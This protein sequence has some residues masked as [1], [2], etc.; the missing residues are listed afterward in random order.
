MLLLATCELMSTL[1]SLSFVVWGY[2]LC[3]FGSHFFIATELCRHLLSV[4]RFP[5]PLKCQ[6]LLFVLENYARWLINLPTLWSWVILFP[7]RGN[8]GRRPSQFHHSV[9]LPN[10]LVI[11]KLPS[12]LKNMLCWHGFIVFCSESRIN[13]KTKSLLDFQR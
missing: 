5:S 7:M 3:L 6:S 13:D 2:L 4:L 11:K 8:L 9:R 1:L 12:L 10:E